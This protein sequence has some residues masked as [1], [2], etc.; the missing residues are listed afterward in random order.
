MSRTQSHTCT[1]A[2]AMHGRWNEHLIQLLQ[3]LRQHPYVVR[4]LAWSHVADTQDICLV[5]E[6]ANHGDLKK[7]N[8]ESKLSLKETIHIFAD[9]ARG[10]QFVHDQK[11]APGDVKAANILVMYM[12]K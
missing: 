1:M 3:T 2:A 9:T 8:L 11:I 7:L 4:L 12:Q 6:R 5:Y 10:L